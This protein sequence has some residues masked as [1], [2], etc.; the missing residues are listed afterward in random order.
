M[1]MAMEDTVATTTAVVAATATTTAAA[2]AFTTALD[3]AMANNGKFKH[4]HGFFG[5]HGKFKKRK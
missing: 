4:R 1:A 2:T 5:H 3:T